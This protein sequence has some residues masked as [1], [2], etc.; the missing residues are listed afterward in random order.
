MIPDILLYFAIERLNIQ[1]RQLIAKFAS[2]HFPDTDTP[3]QP[4]RT[5]NLDVEA[6][7]VALKDTCRIVF[8]VHLND[9][10]SGCRKAKHPVHRDRRSERLDRLPGRASGSE[11]SEHR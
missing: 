4:Y 6:S 3:H 7:S 5:R 8:D 11:D 10:D 1:A 2:R 9:Q